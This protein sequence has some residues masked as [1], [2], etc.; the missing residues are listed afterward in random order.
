VARR[1]RSTRSEKRG[2]KTGPC[3]MGASG[4]RRLYSLRDPAGVREPGTITGSIASSC[5][6]NVKDLVEKIGLKGMT[7][8]S[9][10]FKT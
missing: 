9:G 4:V 2:E 8:K 6:M 3:S 7:V 10:V 5:V 1:R